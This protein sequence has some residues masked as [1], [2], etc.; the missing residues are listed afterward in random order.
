MMMPLDRHL[1]RPG[2]MSRTDL[3]VA[4]IA[5]LFL[6]AARPILAQTTSNTGATGTINPTTNQVPTTPSNTLGT[7][8]PGGSINPSMTATPAPNTAQSQS[9]QYVNPLL[10]APPA[11]NPGSS[12]SQRDA[13][14]R[15]PGANLNPQL[16]PLPECRIDDAACIEQR[17]R[18]NQ[19][20]P[21]TAPTFNR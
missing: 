6:L 18:M 2:R 16:Q 3:M 7:I 1:A 5:L 17:N 19:T 11:V 15:Q 21:Q 20:N 14:A 13:N 9:N 4:I 10:N 8:P 12:Q